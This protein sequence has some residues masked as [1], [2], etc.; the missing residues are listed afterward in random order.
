MQSATATT[1]SRETAPPRSELDADAPRYDRQRYASAARTHEKPLAAPVTKLETLAVFL[2][3]GLLYAL[4]GIHLIGDLHVVNFD[5]LDR[6]TRALVVWHD[7]PPKLAAV[8]F[9]LPPIGTLV[10]VPFA[11]IRDMATSGWALPLSS[12]IFGAGALVFVDRM[13]AMGAMGRGPRLIIV[14]LVGLNPMFAFYAMNGTGD[15]AH[16][17]LAAIGLLCLLGWGRNGSPRYLIAAGLAFSVAVLTDYEYILWTIFLAL[18]VAGTLSL[19]GRERDEVEGSVIAYLAP[20]IYALGAWAF[21]NA[22]VLGDPIAWI[23]TAESAA[24]V[25][26][27]PGE[28]ADFGVIDAIANALRVQLGFPVALL[29]VPLL[30][31]AA[32]DAIGYGLAGLIL[33]SV[34]YSV[35]SAAIAGSVDVI[36][37]RHALPAMMA[38]CAGVAWVYL[39]AERMRALVWGLTALLAAISLPSA[40]AQMRSYPYQN[41]EEAF[42]R[43]ISTGEDQEGTGSRGG[44]LVGVAREREMARYITGEEIGES[45][46]LTDDARTFGVIDLTGEPELFFD[47][48][49]KGDSEWRAALADPQERVDYMLVERTDADLILDRYPGADVG[50]VEGFEP[51]VANDRYALLQVTAD[52]MAP[53]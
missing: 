53:P 44:Y 37:L 33:I 12:A 31:L 40:W 3:F 17:M 9:S 25:N 36:E 20:I 4:L 41:L 16:M 1:A 8:G 39:R 11:A 13:L 2:G 7:D 42:T 51:V 19:R 49:D 10:L 35:I 34:A 6:L 14:L 27:L 29:A 38:G 23:S 26:A 43:A 24:P 28:A 22:V 45:Q 50:D 52:E 46:I 30:L 47:R 5:A 48:V 15:A 32:R 18:L 21:L